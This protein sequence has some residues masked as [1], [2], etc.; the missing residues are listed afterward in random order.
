MITYKCYDCGAIFTEDEAK[1]K[2][3]GIEMDG[4]KEI[5]VCCPNCK[6]FEIEEIS[7][8]QE[9]GAE[10]APWQTLCDDCLQERIATRSAVLYGR[11]LEPEFVKINPLFA[12]IFSRSE[13]DQILYKEMLEDLDFET[14]I[15]V[16]TTFDEI[17]KFC[18]ADRDEFEEYIKKN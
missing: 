7:V 10:V 18:L 2:D 1:T 4:F 17:R 9:C 8:C 16:E 14:K 3:S 15:N 5:C 11:S 6:A 13:I 12:R